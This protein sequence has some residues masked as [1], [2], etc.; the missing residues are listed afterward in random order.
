MTEQRT[1]TLK[2]EP[3]TAEAWEPFGQ[4]PVDETQPVDPV[5]LEFKL[6]DPHCNFIFHGYD[7]L[8]FAPSG[9]ILCDHLNRHDTATQ[10]LMPMNCD[11]VLVVAPATVD[12]CSPDQLDTI[13]AFVMR[14]YE[15]CNLAIG[16]WHWGPFPTRPGRVRLLNVQGK[17]FPDDN[18]VARLDD[19]ALVE[20]VV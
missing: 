14:P 11:A 4:I 20:V 1:I 6:A 7:E 15:I 13:R 5:H 9:N 2:A 10:T 3:L 16:T 17:G 19:Q 8:R 18:L 12:F